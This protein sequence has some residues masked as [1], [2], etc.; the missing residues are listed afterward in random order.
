MSVMDFLNKILAGCGKESEKIEAAGLIQQIIESYSS[1]NL[2]DNE[3]NEIVTQVCIGLSNL[4]QQCGKQYPVDKCIEELTN[5][6]KSN[7]TITSLSDRIRD[8]LRKKRGKTGTSGGIG[9]L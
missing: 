9:L 5:L 1:G 2:T 4:A 3:L 6:I 8:L 7:V